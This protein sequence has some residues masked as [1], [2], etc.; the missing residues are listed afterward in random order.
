MS[1]GRI[2]VRLGVLDRERLEFWKFFGRA[3]AVHRN[4]FAHSM[5]LAVMGYHFRRLND[6]I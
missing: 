6:N 3:L 2:V 5:R 1:L 4:Q